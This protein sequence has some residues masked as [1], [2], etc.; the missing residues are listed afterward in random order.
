M[1]FADP[2]FVRAVQVEVPGV[3]SVSADGQETPGVVTTYTVKA[4]VEPMMTGRDLEGESGAAL[5]VGGRRFFMDLGPAA[6]DGAKALVKFW[7]EGTGAPT[8]FFGEAIIVHNGVSYIVE[9]VM[10]WDGE[11]VEVVGSRRSVG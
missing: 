5:P 3:S 7:D 9:D 4:S 2:F 8:S 6:A 10:T 1:I 11:Y